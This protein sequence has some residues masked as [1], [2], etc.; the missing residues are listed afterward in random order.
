MKNK[1]KPIYLSQKDEIKYTVV[2][3]IFFV[4]LYIPGMVYLLIRERNSFDFVL[5]SSILIGAYTVYSTISFIRDFRRI[6]SFPDWKFVIDQTGIYYNDKE[7]EFYVKWM[8]VKKI[9]ID[10]WGGRLSIIEVITITGKHRRIIPV[11]CDV[12]ASR[13]SKLAQTY[14]CGNG[15]VNVK[16]SGGQ[17]HLWG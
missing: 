17:F 2:Q 5:I 7:G 6:L 4:F 3:I 11:Y 14:S 9:N 8:Y 10:S 16:K 15:Q 13:V 1:Y 12:P